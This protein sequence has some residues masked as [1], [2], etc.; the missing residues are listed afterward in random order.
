L[1]RRSRTR[2]GRARLLTLDAL[3]ARTAAA[4]A[5]RKCI[6]ALTTNLGGEDRL[7]E[8]ERQLV[9]RAALLGCITADFETKW[10]AGE[11]EPVLLAEYLA[12]VNVQR[13]A[14]SRPSQWISRSP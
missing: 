4:Q 1:P 2:Q 14:C 6:D 3:D 11:A 10:I 8:G 13:A 12:A 5:A 9:V 7:S